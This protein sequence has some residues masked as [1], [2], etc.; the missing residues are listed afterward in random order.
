ML[1]T[2]VDNHLVASHLRFL[3]LAPRLMHKRDGIKAQVNEFRP[4]E[5]KTHSADH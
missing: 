5:K 4:S 3:I 2:V 1:V